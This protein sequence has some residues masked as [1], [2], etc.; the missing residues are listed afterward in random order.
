VASRF[1]DDQAGLPDLA[2]ALA[3]FCRE[4]LK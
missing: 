3:A 2:A 1:C 4:Q